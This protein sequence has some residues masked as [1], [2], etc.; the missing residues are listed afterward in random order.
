MCLLICLPDLGSFVT[1][2]K[3]HGIND[4]GFTRSIWTNNTCETLVEG[5]EDLLPR[6]GLEPLV[7]NVGDDEAG[8]AVVQG[9][10]GQGRGRDV[11]VSD[12]DA[13]LGD[14]L[15]LQLHWLLLILCHHSFC[16]QL[17]LITTLQSANL[18]FVSKNRKFNKD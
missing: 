2:Y 14:V 18:D 15:L 12:T 11:D 3:Q 5:P 7:L 9:E 4:V 1:K 13:S 10:G 6:V 8:P 16:S 17:Q